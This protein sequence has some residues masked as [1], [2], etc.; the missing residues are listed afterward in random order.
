VEGLLVLFDYLLF[1]VP[2]KNFSLTHWQRT[3][4]FI[5]VSFVSSGEN[6]VWFDS[7][8]QVCSR[9]RI[10]NPWLVKMDLIRHCDYRNTIES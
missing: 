1:Y 2:L 8:S 4:Y 7:S 10:T 6:P 9:L 5:S 3:D